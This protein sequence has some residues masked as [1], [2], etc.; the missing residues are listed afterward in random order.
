MRETEERDTQA[1]AALEL[2]HTYLDGWMEPE[3]K[4]YALA[5]TD[6]YSGAVFVY[7][8]KS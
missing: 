4:E 3:A 2:V 6:D 5:F 1:K 7:F 8:F